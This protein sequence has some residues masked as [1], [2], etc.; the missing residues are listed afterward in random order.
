MNIL[1]K[2]GFIAERR[3][4]RKVQKNKTL[5]PKYKLISFPH[6]NSKEKFDVVYTNDLKKVPTLAN[7][8]KAKVT[9]LILKNKKGTYSK[10][11][12]LNKKR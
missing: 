7:I 5:K 12:T 11:K 8:K 3:Y 9:V 1:K 4:K 2:I 6:S 10:M